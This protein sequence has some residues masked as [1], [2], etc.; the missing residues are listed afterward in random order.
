MTVVHVRIDMLLLDVLNV[1]PHPHWSVTSP[2]VNLSQ[3]VLLPL[4]YQS[5]PMVTIVRTKYFIENKIQWQRPST[6]PVQTWPGV[7]SLMVIVI[8]NLLITDMRSVSRCQS[9]SQS[10]KWDLSLWIINWG[11]IAR[12]FQLPGWRRLL[13]VVCTLNC[14]LYSLMFPSRPAWHVIEKLQIW[15]SLARQW[16]S[17]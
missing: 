6:Y 12:V 11:N 5:M 3:N 17:C 13:A 16:V 2:N 10:V 8:L 15:T 14:G 9:V 7:W 4:L 1:V